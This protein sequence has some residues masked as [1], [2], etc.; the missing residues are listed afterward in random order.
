MSTG[1]DAST[2][3]SSRDL[4]ASLGEGLLDLRLRFG[5]FVAQDDAAAG[6]TQ[7]LAIGLELLLAQ[8]RGDHAVEQLGMSPTCFAKLLP[9]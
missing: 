8:Q 6:Q 4:Q 3:L 1:N 9:C 5:L 2:S 7:Q